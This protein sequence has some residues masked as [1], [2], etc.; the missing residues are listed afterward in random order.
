MIDAVAVV[1]HQRNN[2]VNIFETVQHGFNV[3]GQIFELRD[4]RKFQMI[5]Q[6]Y[7]HNFKP[8]PLVE[9]NLLLFFYHRFGHIKTTLFA[10]CPMV[11]F[12]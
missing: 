4:H 8:L 2:D 12:L 7:R 11:R 1:T 10:T 3:T 6:A 9:F 5:R